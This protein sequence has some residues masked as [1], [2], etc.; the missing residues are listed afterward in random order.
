MK[1]TLKCYK[2]GEQVPRGDLVEYV[3]KRSK[4]PHR[5]C[6]TCLKTILDA[7]NFCDKITE[8]YKDN[9]SWPTINKRKRLLYETYGY[10]D[11]TI[12]DCL[13]YAYKVKGYV[14]LEKV[15]GIIKPPLVEEML[16]YKK[17]QDFK[18][19]QIVN[20]IIDNTNKT[21]N[22]PQIKIRENMRPKKK[23]TWDDDNFLFME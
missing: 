16:Q 14:V 2:C 22:L 9:I 5:Y 3:T 19:N 15:L 18:E 10:T 13:E 7:E 11:Q 23:S 4:N 1:P 6:P 21:Q 8:F 20:A 12:I 17:V